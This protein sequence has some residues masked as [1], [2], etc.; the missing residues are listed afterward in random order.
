[1]LRAG[2]RPVPIVE[3][4]VTPEQRPAPGQVAKLTAVLRGGE[5]AA[6]SLAQQEAESERQGQ[7]RG[8]RVL[9]RPAAVPACLLT[10]RQRGA[11]RRRP[12]QAV[13]PPAP[14]L[15]LRPRSSA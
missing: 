13:P 11:G 14:V 10:K 15:G 4:S 2:D 1:M 5:R 12:T 7:R 9:G 3:A 8:M 6:A